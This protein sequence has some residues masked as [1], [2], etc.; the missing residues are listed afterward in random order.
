[1]YLL[2][3]DK[4]T[5]GI[6]IPTSMSEIT[7]EV[8]AE[9]TKNIIL[10]PHH[11]LICLV[12]KTTL[13]NLA[14]SVRNGLNQDTVS[15]TPLVAK[16]SDTLVNTQLPVK[17]ESQVMR[18]IIAPSIIE[19]GYEVF[20]PT[21]ASINSVMG[22]IQHD[23]DLRI[24]L[25]QK[26]YKGNAQTL[27]VPLT[28]KIIIEDNNT[29]IYLLGFKIVGNNDIVATIPLKQEIDDMFYIKN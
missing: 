28:D 7:N 11:T 29:D 10:S 25:F 6:N 21:A 1:M 17:E 23:E 3:G 18:P 20:I 9:L 4:A 26:K 5:Y 13:F 15:V 8:L 12:Y 27:G 14:S 2:Q 24:Q 22:Y 16:V 19:R